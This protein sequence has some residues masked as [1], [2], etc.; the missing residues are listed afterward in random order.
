MRHALGFSGGKDSWACLWLNYDRLHE[1]DVIWVNPGKSYPELL[2]T[3]ALARELCPRFHEIKT[4][5]DAQN[6]AWGLP[7]DIVPVDWTVYGRQFA[8]PKPITLQPYFHCCYENIGA[9]LVAHAKALGCTHLIRG[10]RNDEGHVSASRDGDV[11]DGL[12]YVQ[13]IETWTKSEVLEYVSQFMEL[14]AHFAL[15]HSS[16]DCYDC[17]AYRA[18]SKDRIEYTRIEH[19]VLFEAYARRKAAVDS[20]VQAALMEG[21]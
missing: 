18:A 6:A 1:I 19:P 14:P 8:G 12:V 3:V 21:A 10:Q 11:V 20:A 9:A 13:P 5:R 7:S 16:M 2:D 17:T 15:E 4:D